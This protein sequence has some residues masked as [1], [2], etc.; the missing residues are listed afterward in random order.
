MKKFDSDD[1]K[2]LNNLSYGD[3]AKLI[4]F[5]PKR[6]LV[7][8]FCKCDDKQVFQL[9][10]EWDRLNNT[11]LI[12]PFCK[13]LKKKGRESAIPSFITDKYL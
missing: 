3:G 12:V 2:S 13:A 4:K 11:K 5:V 10:E 9:F 8:L 6:V 1:L 7:R